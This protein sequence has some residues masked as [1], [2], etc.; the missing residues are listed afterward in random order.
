MSRRVYMGSIAQQRG[1]GFTLLELL[2]VMV[3][4][5]LLMSILMTGLRSVKRQADSLV[6]MS[7]LRQVAVDFN[8]VANYPM[9]LKRFGDHSVDPGGFGLTSFIDKVYDAGK[10]FAADDQDDIEETKKFVRGSRIA[11]CPAGPG[12]LDIRENRRVLSE[13]DPAIEDARQVS[14]GFN[15]RL[16]KIWRHNESW[17]VTL[18][19]NI[20]NWPRGPKTALVFDVDAKA[21][22]AAYASPHLIAPP[23]EPQGGYAAGPQVELPEGLTW[24]PSRRHNGKTNVALL[25]GSVLSKADLLAHPTHINWAD[26]VYS[27]GWVNGTYQSAE[28]PPR[29]LESLIN[30]DVLSPTE[31]H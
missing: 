25:D 16:R 6:C 13:L 5:A 31:P 20:Y 1:R 30:M 4:I 19:A 26:A 28:G 12:V 11:L 18:S 23:V 2:V 8:F 17:F 29:L 10:Y 9:D 21:A 22:L 24:F 27:G 14:Y 15:A 3:V 7:N